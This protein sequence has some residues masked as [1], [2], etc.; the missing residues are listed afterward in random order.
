MASRLSNTTSS[1]H[2]H[3]MSQCISFC[4]PRESPA[5]ITIGRIR[6][7]R[8]TWR[9]QAHVTCSSSRAS[10]RRGCCSLSAHFLKSPDKYGHSHGLLEDLLSRLRAHQANRVIPSHLRDGRVLDIGCGCTAYFLAHE[11]FVE[12][13]G[14]DRTDPGTPPPAG[15]WHALDLGPNCTCR[16]PMGFLVRSP[17]WLSWNT[18]ARKS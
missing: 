12:K 16:F 5:P 8:S 14:I 4:M 15:S 17:C 1:S 6:W 7:R 10:K 11:L 18:W 2:C 9:L 3:S 13:F